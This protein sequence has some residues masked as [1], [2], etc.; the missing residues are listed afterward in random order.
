MPVAALDYTAWSARYPALAAFVSNDLAQSYWDEAGLFL[1]NTEASPVQDVGRR[2]VLLGLITAHLAQL[3]RPAEAGGSDVVGRVSAASEGSV[4]LSAD[5]GP[6]TA[7]QAWWVQTKWG[8][9]SWAATVFLRRAIYVPGR[10]QR[11]PI[12]P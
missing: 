3:N 6:V 12:W 2:A 7:S 10:P 1:D 9:E 8:A 5:M 4:S 11:F